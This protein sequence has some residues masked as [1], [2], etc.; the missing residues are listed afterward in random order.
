[1][2]RVAVIADDLTGAADTGIQF[3][4]SEAP[5]YLLGYDHIRSFPFPESPHSLS[6]FTNTRNVNAEQAGNTLN[7]VASAI[8]N[9]NPEFIYKKIDS[10]LRGNIGA[11]LDA[12]A[13]SM[14]YEVTFVSSALP[15]QGRTILHDVHYLRGVPLAETEMARDPVSPV[16]ES[17]VSVRL[18]RQSR[19][20]VAR[21]DLDILEGSIEELVAY[22][23]RL[24]R[25]RVKH[26]VFDA[27]TQN[28][29]DRIA[30]L[31]LAH[32]PK[33]LLV[34]SAGLASSLSRI[35]FPSTEGTQSLQDPVGKR[36]LFVCGSASQVLK[37]Q[38]EEL[39]RSSACSSY[40]LDPSELASSAG[41][42]KIEDLSRAAAKDLISG[43]VVLKIRPP[44]LS[45]SPA[46]GQEILRGLT[47]LVLSVMNDVRPDGIFLSGGDTASALWNALDAE[48]ILLGQELLPGFVLGTFCKG[49]LHGLPVVVKPGAFGA[50]DALVRIY[51]MLTAG[52]DQNHGSKP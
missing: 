35:L 18:G 7:R 38:I 32:F 3:C 8:K 22:I 34:G 42:M 27:S 47:E 20:E 33:C 13:E 9:L 51:D 37:A 4:R 46:N 45:P 16:T 40:T 14:G 41:K 12:L 26:L 10:C 28:H 23:R 15:A 2:L 24:I 19:Y 5:T 49:P 39:L 11:E 30:S 29:L 36:I 21:V 52:K 25:R 17:R 1:M 43:S 48:A 44:G 31:A 50:S 6:L